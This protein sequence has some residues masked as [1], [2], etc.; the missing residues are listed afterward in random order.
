MRSSLLIQKREY[1]RS[2]EDIPGRKAPF[3]FALRG[4]SNEQQLFFTS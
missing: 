3:F 1:L 2:E 4:L